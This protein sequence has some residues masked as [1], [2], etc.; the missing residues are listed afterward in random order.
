[1]ASRHRRRWRVAC[2]RCITVIGGVHNSIGHVR[3]RKTI[4]AAGDERS[5][6]GRRERER[7]TEEARQNNS[8]MMFQHIARWDCIN[9]VPY[10]SIDTISR[11]AAINN[12]MF[13][14]RRSER[15]PSPSPSRL[16]FVLKLQADPPPG[17]SVCRSLSCPKLTRFFT[18]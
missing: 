17:R 11:L 2:C 6:R 5:A 3:I 7:E 14:Q 4:N 16:P 15:T 13:A 9:L 1:M 18:D 10:H 8:P 12:D